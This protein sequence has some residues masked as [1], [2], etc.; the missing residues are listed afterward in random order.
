VERAHQNTLAVWTRPNTSKG[1]RKGARARERA[2]ESDDAVEANIDDPGLRV[3]WSH[4]KAKIKGNARRS[5]TEAFFEWAAEHAAQVYEIQ[6]RDAERVIAEL[7]R[8]EAAL[9]KALRKRGP[10]KSPA[11]CGTPACQHSELEAVPF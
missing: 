11:G 4:V 5:R 9:S 3:V 8:Q 7:E 10:Y 1:P 6:E 2:S